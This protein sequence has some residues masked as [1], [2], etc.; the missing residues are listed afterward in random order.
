MCER[1][2]LKKNNDWGLGAQFDKLRKG[3][4]KSQN[5]P[6]VSEGIT[7]LVEENNVLLPYM[8]NPNESRACSSSSSGSIRDKKEKK[9]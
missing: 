9:K 6:A 1:R 4:W 3:D 8:E 2:K 5:C 7:C